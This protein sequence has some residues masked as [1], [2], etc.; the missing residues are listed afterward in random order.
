MKKI[1]LAIIASCVLAVSANAQYIDLINLGST[2]IGALTTQGSS[3]SQT[4]TATLTSGAVGGGDNFYNTDLFASQNWSTS[5]GLWIKSSVTTSANPAM[6]FTLQLFDSQFAE[7]AK[8]QGDTSS[9]VSDSGFSYLNLTAV[10]TPTLTGIRALQFTFDV[11][12]GT[13]APIMSLQSIATVP[14]PSTYALMALGGLALFFIARRRKAQ[15]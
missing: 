8:Y 13:T 12:S 11:A 7:I 4:T 5:Q 6:A 3:W 14:E 9:S 15:A 10:G 2:G 1:T